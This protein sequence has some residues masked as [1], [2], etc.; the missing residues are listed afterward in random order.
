MLDVVVARLATRGDY[1]TR[2]DHWQIDEAHSAHA[3]VLCTGGTA[4]F[5]L[6]TN[7]K[8]M[9]CTAHESPEKGAVGNMLYANYPTCIPVSGDHQSKL[10]PECRSLANDGVLGAAEGAARIVKS[11][12]PQASP[13]RAGG[14]PG[15]KISLLRTLVHGMLHQK[16]QSQVL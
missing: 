4:R 10:Y 6:S 5:Y 3:V 1:H 14:L 2:D 15:K 16:C 13:N 12:R 8:R 9:Q 7:C 11:V